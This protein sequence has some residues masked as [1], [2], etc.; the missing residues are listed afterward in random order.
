MVSISIAIPPE[1]TPDCLTALWKHVPHAEV[2][3]LVRS[4]GVCL[5]AAI[6]LTYCLELTVEEIAA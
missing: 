3:R 2:F 6:R 1:T 5:L 4:G